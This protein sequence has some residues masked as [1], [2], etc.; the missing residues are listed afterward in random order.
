[1]AV[2][3][4]WVDNGGEI[5]LKKIKLSNGEVVSYMHIENGRPPLLMIH[6][7]ISSGIHFSPVIP[8][9][10]QKYD[11]YIPDMREFDN[12]SHINP[13][14]S[15]NELSN[16]IYNFVCKLQLDKFDLLGWSAGGTVCMKFVANY[17]QK[18]KN[19]ILVESVGYKGCPIFDINGKGYESIE[20][21]GKEL[22]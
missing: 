2:K 14:S 13:I 5:R 11:L 4:T 16:D 6:G 21:M 7:N 1:M 12:S 22:T 15:I 18:V 9:I 20:A 3:K 17:P 10:S 19:L 8:Y